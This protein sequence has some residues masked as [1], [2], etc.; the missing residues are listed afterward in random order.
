MLILL[1]PSKSL[2]STPRPAVAG[3]TTPDF[4]DEAEQ[5]VERLRTY[6]PKSLAK[7]MDVSD[8]LADEN[9]RRYRDWSRPFTPENAAPAILAFRGDVYL[10]LNADTL[11]SKALAFAKKQ[12]R[13]LSGL[14]G[15][16]R[17]LDLIQPYRL[18][19]GTTFPKGK[20]KTLYEF[21]GDR[22]ADAI[23]AEVA[24]EKRPVVV[25]LA[26]DEYFSAVNRDALCAQVVTPTFK[27]ERDGKLKHLSFF[28]KRARGLMARYVVDRRI[29]NTDGLLDF[30]IEGYSYNADAS[31]DDELVF[32]RPQP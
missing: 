32:S 24:R 14:Y 5:L 9:H 11:D 2:D 23:N 25:N 3:T 1:S 31:T 10:G 8:K 21:W 18:V 22:I 30:D 15:Y 27:Q 12:L 16:L 28:A 4:L 20:P 26:S 7:L 17:P 29:K 6:S 13:I 19:M